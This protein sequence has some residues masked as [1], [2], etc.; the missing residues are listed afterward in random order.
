MYGERP[1][2]AHTTPGGS[3]FRAGPTRFEK[4]SYME[5]GPCIAHT[6]PHVWVAPNFAKVLLVVRSLFMYGEAPLYSWLTS[7]GEQKKYVFSS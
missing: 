2:F 1:F 7:E 5:K 3:E 6:T 4:L